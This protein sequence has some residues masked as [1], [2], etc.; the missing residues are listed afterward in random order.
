MNVKWIYRLYIFF[1]G[2]ILC[3]TTGFGIAAFYPQ[4]SYPQYPLDNNRVIV[5]QSCYETPQAQE[6]ANCQKYLNQQQAEQVKNV[7]KQNKY[8][9][10]LEAYNNKNAG[11]TRTAVFLGIASGSLF[12]ILGIGFMKYS[13]TVANGVIL[14]GVLTAIFTRFLIMLASFGSQVSGTSGGD[15][16]G[17]IEFG[18]LVILSVAVIVVG[19]AS[20]KPQEGK[21]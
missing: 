11:Y 14:G 18:I 16:L 6:T 15:T 21:A 17:Y 19:F 4:P 5:P 13:H 3:T 10:K 2:I 7:E 12:A 20:L 8:S 1:V 9:T